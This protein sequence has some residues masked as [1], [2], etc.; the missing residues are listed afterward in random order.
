[1]DSE[2]ESHQMA[3]C[4]E[5]RHNCSR[6][7]TVMAQQRAEMKRTCS[8]LDFKK[9]ARKCVSMDKLKGLLPIIEWAPKYRS[10]L[11]NYSLISSY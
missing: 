5:V 2:D 11:V 6:F 1:M 4:D 3:C 7:C 8:K 9:T 10:V